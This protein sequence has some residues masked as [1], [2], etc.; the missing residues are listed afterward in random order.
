[1]FLKLLSFIFLSHTLPDS[2]AVNNPLRAPVLNK[3]ADPKAI[4]I[5]SRLELF[6]DDY[7]I[8]RLSGNVRSRL[9]AP[10]P[11]EVVLVHDAPWEGSGSGYHSVFQDGNKYRMYYKSWH[12]TASSE[13]GKVHP[14]FCAYAESDDGIVWKKPKLG[15]H[16]FNG[17][18]ANNIVLVSGD[19]KGFKI[20]A[21]HP[22]VFKDTNPKAPADARYKAIVALENPEYGLVALKSPD[23]IHWDLLDNGIFMKDG[24]FDSQ[25]LAFWDAEIGAYRTYWRQYSKN[26]IRGIRTAVSSNLF[27]WKER[28]ELA[29]PGSPDEHLY[30]NQIKP[31]HRAPHI[32]MG[33]PLHYVDRGWSESMRKLPELEEREKR[34]G[35]TTKGSVADLTSRYGTVITE[36]LFMSSRDGVN[37]KRWN[38]AFMRPGIERDG[39]WTYGD[40]CM[41]WHI[42]ETKSDIEGAPNELS[43]YATENYWKGAGSRLR[44]FTLRLDGFVSIQGDFKGGEILTKPITF[45]GKELKLNF[46]TS[47]AGSVHVE[48]LDEK[49]KP[50]PGF[51]IKDAIPLFGDA[52]SKTVV[53]KGKTSVENL[54]GK[55]IQLRIE[56]KDADIYSF[57]FQ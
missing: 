31:Y 33:F 50:V 26:G 55:A 43:L 8:Q 54:Q 28:K 48:I 40:N 57:Q 30:T 5:G 9:H 51:S 23:G 10:V 32:M 21:G 13:T 3:V 7:L 56:L 35:K 25:N 15:I 49:G 19:L 6:V 41:A 16:E 38:E 27:D 45:K 34:A 20:D 44:R 37:F 12:H 22:A 53:W 24:H 4:P 2:G 46:S 17:S 14:L 52:V 18:K 1:M 39:S 11:K 47:A 42:V 36:T 29:Y